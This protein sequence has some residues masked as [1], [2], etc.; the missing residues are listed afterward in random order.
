LPTDFGAPS[1][2]A[3]DGECVPTQR[4]RGRLIRL[5]EMSE[6][7]AQPLNRGRGGQ[8]ARREGQTKRCGAASHA[9]GGAGCGDEYLTAP[10]SGAEP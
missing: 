8:H 2:G 5:S 6:D 10:F 1:L 3:V 4:Y 7:D 9:I